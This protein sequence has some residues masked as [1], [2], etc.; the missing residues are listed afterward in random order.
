[1]LRHVLTLTCNKINV[2]PDFLLAVW[3]KWVNILISLHIT[4]V[5]HQV[6]LCIVKI[7]DKNS[8]L[9]ITYLQPSIIL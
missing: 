3:C 2:M 7:S 6:A 9:L 5:T 4:F 8:L 1:M